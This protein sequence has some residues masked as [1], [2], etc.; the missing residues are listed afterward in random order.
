MTRYLFLVARC[1]ARG[2]TARRLC[3]VV[4][5]TVDAGVFVAVVAVTVT[6]APVNVMSHD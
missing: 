4:T 1:T 3:V 6:L 5:V 2:L